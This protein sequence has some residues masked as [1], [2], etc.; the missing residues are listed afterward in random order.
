M[1]WCA[2]FFVPL[3]QE[4]IDIVLIVPEFVKVFSN[5]CNGCRWHQLEITVELNKKVG[6]LTERN[7]DSVKTT[8]R[9][10]G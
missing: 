7:S 8:V 2:R 1:L 5:S 9:I 4:V 3:L 10:G 6:I